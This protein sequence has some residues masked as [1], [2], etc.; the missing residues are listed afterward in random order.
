MT[1]T[2]DS[3]CKSPA[4]SSV[5]WS[6][7][8]NPSDRTFTLRICRSMGS[9]QSFMK[10]CLQFFDGTSLHGLNGGHTAFQCLHIHFAGHG[11]HGG[12]IIFNKKSSKV[13]AR[14]QNVRC[15][16]VHCFPTKLDSL[17]RI[18]RFPNFETEVER[19][20]AQ[21]SRKH[22]KI[23]QFSMPIIAPK[24]ERK[25]ELFESQIWLKTIKKR[26]MKCIAWYGHFFHNKPAFWLK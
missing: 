1:V 5:W 4:D 12:Q 16:K 25:K 18:W 6:S 17:R 7:T 19:W 22:C 11:G 21:D 26:L 20:R 10:H 13:E 3:A 15:L 24:P 14:L 8:K 9:S 2:S 23:H